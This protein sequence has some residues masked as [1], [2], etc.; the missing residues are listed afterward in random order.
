M[1]CAGAD[2][3]NVMMLVWQ[4]GR[5]TESV[6]FI[7]GRVSRHCSYQVSCWLVLSI[8]LLLSLAVDGISDCPNKN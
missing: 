2:S 8:K 6:Q 1:L 7:D 3:D 5:H 4:R